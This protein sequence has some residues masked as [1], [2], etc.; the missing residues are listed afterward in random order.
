MQAELACLLI[1]ET[2]QLGVGG[3][4]R[5]AEKALALPGPGRVARRAGEEPDPVLRRRGAAAECGGDR[6][7]ARSGRDGADRRRRLRA[8]AAREEGDPET[9]VREDRVA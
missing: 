7:R 6:R 5:E 9:A 8:V 4:R 1:V 2:V 3:G